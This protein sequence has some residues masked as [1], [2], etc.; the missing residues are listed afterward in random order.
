MSENKVAIFFSS[1]F[2]SPLISI[3]GT[4]TVVAEGNDSS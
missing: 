1:E 2:K 4:R 3:D